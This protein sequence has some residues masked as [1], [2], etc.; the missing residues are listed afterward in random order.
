MKA[1]WRQS[2]PGFGFSRQ[3]N[4]SPDRPFESSQ[5]KTG[6]GTLQEIPLEE[7]ASVVMRWAVKD[8]RRKP[9]SE[10]PLLIGTPFLDLKRQLIRLQCSGA[11]IFQLKSLIG[12]C[13]EPL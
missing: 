7:N 6:E 11:F 2:S 5:A 13:L 3:S 4:A 1:A 12:F 8:G 10:P 9:G